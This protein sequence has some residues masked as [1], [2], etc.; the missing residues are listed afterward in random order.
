MKKAIL[1]ALFLLTLASTALATETAKFD[2]AK[3][4]TFSVGVQ[5]EFYQHDDGV[6]LGH[7]DQ[8]Q[9]TAGLFGSFRFGKLVSAVASQT[10]G[11][12]QHDWR[13]TVGLRVTIWRGAKTPLDTPSGQ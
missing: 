9:W 13:T 11:L 12:E 2:F 4:T 6:L 5:R 3:R 8:P 1:A 7:N 10:R